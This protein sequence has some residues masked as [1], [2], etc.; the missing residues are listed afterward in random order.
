MIGQLEAVAG[1]I[2]KSQYPAPMNA[3]RSE[4]TKNTQAHYKS[5]VIDLEAVVYS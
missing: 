5:L 1:F 4:L 3:L 2:A